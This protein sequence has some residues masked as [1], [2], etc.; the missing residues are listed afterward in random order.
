MFCQITASH[1]RTNSH[2]SHKLS[3]PR[4]QDFIICI[5]MF[6]AAMAHKYS[7]PHQPYH[8]NVPDYRVNST[9][10]SSLTAM[11]DMADIR[12]DVTEHFGVV[13]NSLS[14][15]FRGRS[16]YN[17]SRGT[18]ETHRLMTNSTHETSPQ[19]QHVYNPSASD[20]DA[21]TSTNQKNRYGAISS[22]DEPMAVNDDFVPVHGKYD[23]INISKHN[24]RAK[25]YSPQYGVPRVL[26][27]Y[28]AHQTHTQSANTLTSRTDRSG[29]S[30]DNTATRS[31]SGFDLLAFDN[32]GEES[33]RTNQMKKPDSAASDWLSTP[34]DD[35]T[36]IDVKGVERNRS[37][38]QRDP[39]L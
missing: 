1:A 12:Q 20:S 23:G 13:G 19:Y 31:D 18:S 17:L 36:G 2:R 26:G 30:T 10:F 32:C 33:A 14:R 27:N 16:S 39:K 34:T 15:H 3:F 38:F 28:F 22:S 9:W 7:F 25:D 35:F 37:H 5:E 24:Q 11:W 4:I 29:R 21:S 6:I 8:I